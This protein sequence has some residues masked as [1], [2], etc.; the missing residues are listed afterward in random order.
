MLKNPKNAKLALQ[1]ITGLAAMLA[2]GAIHKANK[3]A[4]DKINERYNDVSENPQQDDQ[5]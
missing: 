3:A 2:H 4:T 5:N 1:I